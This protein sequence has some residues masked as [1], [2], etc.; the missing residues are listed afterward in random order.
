M[1]HTGFQFLTEAECV[2]FEPPA[3]SPQQQLLPSTLGQS[4]G[5]E[6]DNRYGFLAKGI[7][8]TSGLAGLF[9]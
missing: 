5:S 8:S 1:Y 6:I 4:R 2:A 9:L 3:E 7:S